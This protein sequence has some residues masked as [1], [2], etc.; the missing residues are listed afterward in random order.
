MGNMSDTMRVAELQ[1]L[2]GDLFE[3]LKIE[4]CNYKVCGEPGHPFT[5]G[6]K[7]VDYAAKYHSNL[8]GLETLKVISCAAP[9]CHRAYEDHTHDTVAF[10]KLTRNCKAEEASAALMNG[11]AFMEAEDIDGVAFVETPEKYRVAEKET[12]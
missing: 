5:I 2:F 3:V 6:P 8:L 9:L 4:S 7:H 1:A 11:K 12:V 10:V